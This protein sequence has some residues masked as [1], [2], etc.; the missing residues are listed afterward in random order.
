MATTGGTEADSG[1]GA[2]ATR[3]A[4][5]DRL[6]LGVPAGLA[7]T[8]TPGQGPTG[9]RVAGRRLHEGPG[10][11]ERPG[12]QPW[13]RATRTRSRPARSGSIRAAT[14]PLAAASAIAA[15]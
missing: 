3:A 11:R 15:G 9:T 1:T 5:T 14:S 4:R 10:L 12:D 8:P 13:R 6:I 7:P 2:D